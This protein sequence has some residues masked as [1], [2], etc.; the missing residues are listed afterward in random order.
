VASEIGEGINQY[1]NFTNELR[2]WTIEGKSP[3]CKIKKLIGK[4]ML[5]NWWSMKRVVLS[6]KPKYK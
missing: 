1:K 2:N 3:V 5:Y 4:V 6:T